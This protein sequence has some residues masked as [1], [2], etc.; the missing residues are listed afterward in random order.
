MPFVRQLSMK[1]SIA[2]MAEFDGMLV[3]KPEECGFES[4]LGHLS[5]SKKYVF[6]I[7]FNKYVFKRNTYRFDLCPFHYTVY[8]KPTM[9]IN[10]RILKRLVGYKCLLSK[11][12]IMFKKIGFEPECLQSQSSYSTIRSIKPTNCR[13]LI[14]E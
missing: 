8:N 14:F 10:S 11:F 7:F 12:V 4:H 3:Y 9:P 13:G 6:R 5:R 2:L 1:L